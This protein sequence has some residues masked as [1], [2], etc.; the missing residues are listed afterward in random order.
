MAEEGEEEDGVNTVPV[1]T[2]LAQDSSPFASDKRTC[3]NI[4][5]G[6][7]MTIDQMVRDFIIAKTIGVNGSDRGGD[8]VKAQH[9]RKG[10]HKSRKDKKK[11]KKKKK[12]HKSHGK[13]SSS[14]H[15]HRHHR[16]SLSESSASDEDRQQCTAEGVKESAEPNHCLNDST[17]ET[18]RLTSAEKNEACGKTS[19]A[20]QETETKETLLNFGEC[21]NCSC[22]RQ[23]STDTEDR[24][25]KTDEE[26]C[27]N[28]RNP[29][30]TDDN[31]L[32]SKSET[33]LSRCKDDTAAT[34]IAAKSDQEC[35]HVSGRLHH[36]SSTSDSSSQ[37]RESASTIKSSISLDSQSAILG[38]SSK[39]RQYTDSNKT[40][41]SAKKQHS[42][43]EHRSSQDVTSRNKSASGRK[44]SP[45]LE[46]STDKHSLLADCKSDDVVFV[47][48]VSAHDVSKSSSSRDTVSKGEKSSR[49]HK[50]S[51]GNSR[52][53]DSRK[54]SGSKR[55]YESESGDEDVVVAKCRSKKD[56][57]QTKDSPV[58]LLSDDDV[59]ILSDEMVEK[60]HKR[61]T[62]S[63]KK[64]K[65]LQAERE[66]TIAAS[67][68]TNESVTSHGTE[69]RQELICCDVA[70]ASALADIIMPPDS[71]QVTGESANVSEQPAVK[72]TASVLL[73][74][75]TLKFGLK[76]SESSAAWISKGFKSDQAG[77]KV[78]S[79]C[80][81]VSLML[82]GY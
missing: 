13:D 64:S 82:V 12:K 81:F 21:A 55:R 3:S 38:T 25:T 51:R 1:S 24:K 30:K 67:A 80:M 57:R 9:D 27:C 72:S 4:A 65:E 70:S 69:L 16:D 34:L 7:S 62:T 20:S 37:H 66:L 15:R 63:I 2:E 58:I 10:H 41:D 23:V 46:K 50:S 28:C 45:S 35:C 59:D 71:A 33:D 8:N 18:S 60:L 53:S 52:S 42:H 14:K 48:K 75:K 68:K 31:R 19:A 73:G 39:N 77:K 36:S 61:L 5:T 26:Q 44:R 11:K 32:V 17:G 76:I 47:K 56:G 49:E 74:K 29:T 54:H 22:G 40:S 6:S 43:R 78:Q 79:C